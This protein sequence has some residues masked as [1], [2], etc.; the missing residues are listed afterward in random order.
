MSFDTLKTKKARRQFI[1]EKLGTDIRWATRG[2]LRI[3]DNQTDDEQ[4]AEETKY[5]NNI[6]FTGADAHIL[7]SFAT[8]VLKGFSLSEKQQKIL[9]KKMPKYSS[10]LEHAAS[11]KSAAEYHQHDLTERMRHPDEEE[12]RN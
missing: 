12:R 1:R 9:F 11:G 8:Q 6:G 10:Q 7:S 3:Y 2:L 4:R 5:W